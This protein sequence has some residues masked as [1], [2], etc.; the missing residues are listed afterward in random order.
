MYYVY[1]LKSTKDN[2]LYLGYTNDLRRRL[3]QHNNGESPATKYRRPLTLRYYESY[4]AEKDA[5]T[6]EFNLKK[7]GNALAQ[8]KRRIQASLQ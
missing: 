3:A 5:K 8:L 1:I 4:Y 7:N 6:R 2:E